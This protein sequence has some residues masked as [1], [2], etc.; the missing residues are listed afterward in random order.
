MG[1]NMLEMRTLKQIQPRQTYKA[2]VSLRAHVVKHQPKF[3]RAD[4]NQI[5]SVHTKGCE[6]QP[7]TAAKH[8]FRRPG[9]WTVE[10]ESTPDLARIPQ[11]L[12]WLEGATTAL[13]GV[14]FGAD[15]HY[16]CTHC[17]DHSVLA[18]CVESLTRKTSSI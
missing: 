3:L 7:Q 1:S 8:E 13:L 6:L 5:S 9:I 16:H 10:W 14:P 2:T 12:Q 18:E 15:D 11:M 4:H 17:R